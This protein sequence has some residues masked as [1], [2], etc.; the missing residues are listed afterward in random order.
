MPLSDGTQ[1]VRIGREH[2]VRLGLV[3]G[4]RVR[5]AWEIRSPHD[6]GEVA[7]ARPD[8]FG[9]FVLVVRVARDGPS[10]ADQFQVVTI[11]GQGDVTSFAVSS[12]AFAEGPP[13]ARFELDV[14]GHLYQLRTSADGMRI[15][16][17]DLEVTP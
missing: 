9:G 2:S 4:G 11:S 7:L 8:G 6:L 3:D 1:F 13:L 5:S 10:P 16:R 15:E 17:F 14:H 12:E